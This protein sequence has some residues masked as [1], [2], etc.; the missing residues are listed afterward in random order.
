M[1]NNRLII[2]SY[3]LPF[4]IK[5]DQ[6]TATVQSSSGGLVTAVKSLDLSQ[7]A[8]KPIWIGCAD[9]TQRQWEKHRHLVDDDFE[10]V[11]VFLDKATQKGFYNGFSN[12]VLWPLF[13]YFPSYVDYHDEHLRAYQAANQQVCETVV[14]HLQPNDEVWV[15]DYHFLGL[16]QLIR[17]RVPT[18]SIGFFLHI[19]FP[20]NEM[21]RLLPKRCRDYLLTGLLGANLIGFHT[22]DYLIHFLE[23]VQLNL[24]LPHQMA[25][26]LYQ[27]HCVQ[28]QAFP[29]GI[30]YGLY[31]DAYDEPDVVAER[32][33]LHQAYPGK[34]IFSVDR[35]DY[36]KGVMQR[37]D[38]LEAFLQTHS[39]WIGKL[40]FILV[41]IPSRDEIQT[42]WERK[43]M[44]EQAV[45]R[46]NGKFATLTWM[47]IV[48]RYASL[49][50]PQL[51]GLYTACDVALITPLRDGMNLVA[52]EFIASRQ[53][54]QGVLVLS[55]L[56]GA[57][58]ELGQALMVNPLDEYEVAER[59]AEALAMPPEEQERR[60][61]IMQKRISTYS[62]QE[63]AADFFNVLQTASRGSHQKS[64]V[65]AL[66]GSSKHNLLVAYEQAQSRLLL[67]DYDGTMAEFTARPDQTT[68][69]VEVISLIR[70]LA[71]SPQNNV[72]IISERSHET[73]ESL[74]EGLPID[75]V[76]EHGTYL[77]QEGIWRSSILDDSHWK[78]TVRP[79]LEGFV[80]RCDGSFIDEKSHSI[81]WHYRE[82]SETIGFERSRELVLTLN[83]LLPYQL[84]AIDGN[85]VVEVK[86][87]DTDKGRMARQLAMAYPYDFVLAVGDDS[88]DEDMFRDLT[89]DGHYT[90]KVGRGATTA[91]YRLD[92]V[93]EVLSLLTAFVKATPYTPDKHTGSMVS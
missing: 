6:K 51:M 3:R 83:A 71:A 78:E 81:A 75:I 34:I 68:P 60:I 40:V 36:T 4:S 91:G 1:K 61:A 52:K 29:I 14:E 38:A 18:A 11:P 20:S 70:E 35:L 21:L 37:L 64:Q 67:L 84:R 10:Y 93:K 89:G 12:S 69:S 42:Y 9:F 92:S 33:E 25:K 50:F 55:E 87:A 65:V 23:S 62:V 41:V 53:D 30:N 73:L 54:Q 48:Y 74:L 5:T 45:G 85:K 79:L 59:L 76:A 27:D 26:I 32:A 28:G 46:I 22:N 82:V 56:T 17:E 63:W 19:P 44:I 90:V 2:I 86:I 31:H 72:V 80:S 58:N 24:G 66:K 39:E 16:P 47:P 57:A 88:T 13:H 7:S 49:S 15:H 77:R 43:Q 8:H